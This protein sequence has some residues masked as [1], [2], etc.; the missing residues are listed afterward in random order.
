MKQAWSVF[1]TSLHLGLTSFG[2]PIAHL[3]YFEHAYVKKKRWI[4]HEEYSH[5]VAL[6]QL[7][8]GPTSSQVNF[9]IGLQ[10]AGWLGALLSW[11]GF[12]LPSAAILYTFAIFSPQTHGPWMDATLHGL[13]LVAVAIVAQAVWSMA[14]RLCPDRSRAGIALAGIVVLLL[15]GGA[16]AQIMV[17]ALGAMAGWRLCREVQPIPGTQSS[18]VKRRV[19][20]I[21]CS[22]FFLLLAALP[23]INYILPGGFTH[24][25]DVSYRSGSLVFGGGHV[26]LPL[27]R[28]AMVPTGMITDDIFLA[29][30][31]MAQAIPGPLFT[32]SAYLGAMATPSGGSTL[33]WSVAALVFIFLPGILTALAGIPLW[34][35]LSKHPSARGALAGI[36]AAVVGILGA[37]LYDPVLKT[38]ILETTDVVISVSSFFLL[39]RWKVSPIVIVAFCVMASIGIKLLHSA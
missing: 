13:K 38:A 1:L 36:N 35:W 25:I 2:G 8:P 37:A 7:L 24:L 28:D 27:L 4:S 20:L 23:A 9:L 16:F 21:S 29:G 3:G 26:V 22:L 31:G 30:Y 39:E 19:A 5:M 11:I 33:L 10:K 34:Q 32:L 18:L 17:I 14:A 15:I 6:C 12:T